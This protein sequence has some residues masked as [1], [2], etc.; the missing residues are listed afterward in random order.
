[1]SLRLYRI[2]AELFEPALSFAV[3]MQHLTL[4]GVVYPRQPFL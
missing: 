1:M 4:V 2:A 3:L